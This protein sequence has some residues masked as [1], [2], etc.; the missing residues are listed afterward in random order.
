LATSIPIPTRSAAPAPNVPE[1]IEA[2]IFGI[3]HEAKAKSSIDI[4]V[5]KICVMGRSAV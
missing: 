3:I 4:S 1:A 5:G 2:A